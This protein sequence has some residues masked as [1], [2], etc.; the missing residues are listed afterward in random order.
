MKDKYILGAI[1]ANNNESN[2]YN[3]SS[4][5]GLCETLCL[6][7]ITFH[8]LDTQRGSI[9]DVDRLWPDNKVVYTFDSSINTTT[10][11]QITN[12]MEHI[13][14]KTDNCITFESE[15]SS[16]RPHVLIKMSDK[17]E[18]TIGKSV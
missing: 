8:F 6:N 18:S 16:S 1:L 12:A 14:M 11:A 15:Q 3:C 13:R 7:K 9:L 5:P 4:Y 2:A 17:C 10:A